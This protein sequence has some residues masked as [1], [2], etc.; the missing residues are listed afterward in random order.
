MFAINRSPL[1]DFDNLLQSLDSMQQYQQYQRWLQQQ[2]QDQR[3]RI[4]KKVEAE[5]KYQIQI[6]KK[7]GDFNSYE[8]KVLRSHPLQYGRSN[9]INL[10][11]QSVE[12]DFKK[13]FQFNLDDIEVNDIDW[14]YFPSDNVLVLNVPKKEKYCTDDQLNSMLCSMFGVPGFI[15]CQVARPESQ[16][17]ESAEARKARKAEAKRIREAKRAEEERLRMEREAEEERI[18]QEREAE[19]ERVRLIREAEAREAA[20]QR[21]REEERQRRAAEEKARRLQAV[22]ERKLAEERQA[23]Q[24]AYRKQQEFL[25]ALFGAA[26]SPMTASV[27]QRE[28]AKPQ[29]PKTPEPR[30]QPKEQPKEEPKKQEEPESE[31]SDSES[32]NSDVLTPVSSPKSP[33]SERKRAGEELTKG[34]EKLHRHP[35]LEEV[36]DEEFVMFRKKFGEK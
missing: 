25:Q 29:Q 31:I 20:L 4:V 16:P 26:F 35:S 34:M 24:E 22:R 23:Q 15:P 14:E 19:Q 30:Q 12:D 13:V 28:A 6:F 9:L 11:I 7:S 10:V 32:I 18:R 21:A 36:E 1:Y 5:D 33:V 3:P 8:V 27:P 17:K 2:Y